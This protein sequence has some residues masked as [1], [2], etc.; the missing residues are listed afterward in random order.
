[1]RGVVNTG[2]Q[3]YACIPEETALHAR[4]R[5]TGTKDRQRERERERERER[6]GGGCREVREGGGGTMCACLPRV[7]CIAIRRHIK[8]ESQAGLTMLPLAFVGVRSC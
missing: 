5:K 4:E 6:G 8:Y 2:A 1:L 3:I 7:I